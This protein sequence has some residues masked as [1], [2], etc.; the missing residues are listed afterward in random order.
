M[1]KRDISNKGLRV[2]SGF[3][4]DRAGEENFHA[5]WDPGAEMPEW[6]HRNEMAMEVAHNDRDAA[7]A[8]MSEPS[9]ELKFCMVGKGGAF[10]VQLVLYDSDGVSKIIRHEWHRRTLQS[11]ARA[12]ADAR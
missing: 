5:L 2:V 8:L 4:V 3:L 11:I 1:E 10:L 12:A 9:F 7:A 6:T